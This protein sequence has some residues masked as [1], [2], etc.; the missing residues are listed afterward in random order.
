MLN[1]YSKNQTLLLVR[2]TPNKEKERLIH[3]V[4]L[5]ETL[6]SFLCLLDGEDVKTRDS[7]TAFNG[8]T[9]GIPTLGYQEDKPV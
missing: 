8:R 3:A 5:L 1:Y 6:R 9:F 7:S 2:K 4:C